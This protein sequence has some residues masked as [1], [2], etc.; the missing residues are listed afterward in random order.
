M[1]TIHHAAYHEAG[2]AIATVAA[3]RTVQ[4]PIPLPPHFVKHVTIHV[5]D[6]GEWGGRCCGREIYSPNM[7]VGRISPEWR[8]RSQAALSDGVEAR[9]RC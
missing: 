7:P 4:R 3:F 9:R 1:T 8:R 6:S 2:H 5:R